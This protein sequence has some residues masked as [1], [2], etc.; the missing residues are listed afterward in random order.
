MHS[1]HRHDT[2]A[3]PARSASAPLPDPT[4]ALKREGSRA[5]ESSLA[6]ATLLAA[7]VW[8]GAIG[9]ASAATE[10]ADWPQWGGPGRNFVLSD[11]GLATVWPE[12][13]PSVLWRRA[14]GDHGHSAIVAE[15]GRLYTSYRRGELDVVVAIDAATGATLWEQSYASPLHESYNTEFGPGPHSTPALGADLVFTVSSTL[16]VT[17]WDKTTGERRWA[18]D[19]MAELEWSPM[20]RGYGSSPLLWRD[21]VILNAGGQGQGVV[22]LRQRDGSVAWRALDTRGGYSSPVLMTLDGVEQVVIAHGTTRA[23]L[24]PATGKVH[25]RL[26]LPEHASTTMSTQLQIGDDRIFGS[27]A[28][29]DGS[30]MLRVARSADGAW[31]AEEIWYSRGMRIMHGTVAPFDELVY[32]SSGDFGPAFLAALRLADGELAFRQRGFAK[33]NVMRVGDHVLILDEDGVLALG[34]PGPKAIEILARAQVLD[35]VSWTAPTL[36]GSTLFVRNRTEM[37]ALDLGRPAGA[38]P[39]EITSASDRPRSPTRR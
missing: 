28:Y 38:A 39:V 16:D 23:G 20:F 2:S 15:S 18:R 37:V 26:D 24:D 1:R 22:A 21:L 4:H 8:L 6:T 31:S 25:W 27:S 17:A 3:R 34:D 14:L 35:G 11:R 29:A 12:S 36:V 33:A 10:T 5:S 7:T 13:G 19:L 30:R 32:G 9:A